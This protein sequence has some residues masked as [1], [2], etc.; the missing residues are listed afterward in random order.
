MTRTCLGEET[1]D[2]GD[3]IRNEDKDEDDSVTACKLP[4]TTLFHICPPFSPGG[5]KEVALSGDSLSLSLA[6]IHFQREMYA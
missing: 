1:E 6:R 3:S 5:D 4:L 2:L